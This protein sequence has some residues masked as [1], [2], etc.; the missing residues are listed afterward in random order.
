LRHTAAAAWLSSGLPLEYVRRQMGH[1]SITTTIANY[2]H[3]EPSMMPGAAAQTEAALGIRDIDVTWTPPAA[4]TPDPKTPRLRRLR[5][6][7]GRTRTY[8][9]PVNSRMLCH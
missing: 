1:R 5:S 2:R 3:L 4:T 8:N 7:S 9:P 6:S